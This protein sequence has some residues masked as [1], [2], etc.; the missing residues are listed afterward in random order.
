MERNKALEE[1]KLRN[2]SDDII[3]HSLAVEAI[4][5]KLAT[6]LN[7]H[8]NLWGIA[9]LVHDIDYER[10]DG[11]MSRHGNMAAEILELLNCDRTV[12]YAVRAHNPYNNLNRRRKIDRA[13]YCSSPIAAFLKECVLATKTKKIKDL[14]L[15]FVLDCY[16]NKDF[17]QDIVR[18]YINACSEIDLSIEAFFKLSLE[19]LQEISHELEQE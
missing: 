1:L 11:D 9:G 5:R 19:A 12:I 17:A 15:D 4:M 6:L 13:L 10:V 14:D 2:E 7:E 18:D 3:K 16:N 8:E